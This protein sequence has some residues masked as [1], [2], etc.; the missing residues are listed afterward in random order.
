MN[1]TE[2][3]E[4]TAAAAELA[5]LV[6]LA[7]GLARRMRQPLL[8]L[9]RLMSPIE[10]TARI[11]ATLPALVSHDML[12]TLRD[13]LASKPAAADEPT[14]RRRAVKAA[15]AGAPRERS[16]RA[17]SAPMTEAAHV[18]KRAGEPSVARVAAAVQRSSTSASAISSA[19]SPSDSSLLSS[20]GAKTVRDGAAGDAA[21]SRAKPTAAAI[22]AAAPTR[23][24][25]SSV[26]EQRRQ[27]RLNRQ[28][29]AGM[30]SS[31]SAKSG[32]L[33]AATDA[34][35]I[36]QAGALTRLLAPA[37]DAVAAMERVDA[38]RNGYPEPRP[39]QLSTLGR[40]MRRE[41]PE[42]LAPARAE[43][44]SE[45]TGRPI[46]APPLARLPDALGRDELFE[47]AYRQGVDLT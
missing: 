1:D 27:L 44:A 35:P 18:D 40:S 10:L 3:T 25:R 21:D 45:A 9:E 7:T 20:L 37:R 6:G 32:E 23:A 11:Q 41:I 29:S 36:M 28:R 31:D 2:R 22:T 4:G 42:E 47:D 24:A 5:P 33:A 26:A 15:A 12:R 38:G 17:V 43:A 34:P 14:A 39:T 46:D 8:Q 30:D 16:T 19:T 13:V